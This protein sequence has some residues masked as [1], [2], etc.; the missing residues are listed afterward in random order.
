M[1]D[2]GMGIAYN[3]GNS[4]PMHTPCHHAQASCGVGMTIA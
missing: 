1:Y 2:A 4:S 3:R